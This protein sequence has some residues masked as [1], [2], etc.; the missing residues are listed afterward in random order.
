MGNCSKYLNRRMFF[1]F[2]ATFCI[3]YISIF[4][5][6]NHMPKSIQKFLQTI[7]ESSKLIKNDS[8][9]DKM[10]SYS[11]NTRK[12]LLRFRNRKV[13]RK[14]LLL[15]VG[16]FSAAQFIERR[17]G[18]RKT[19]MT[20]CTVERRISCKFFTDSLDAFGRPI[21]KDELHIL[22]EES[23]R[24]NQDL[25]IVESPRGWNLALR[26]LV[27]IENARKEADFEFFLRIDDDHF[28]CMDRLI[29]ELPYRP[30]NGLVWGWQHC[31]APG[32]FLVKFKHLLI[33]SLNE[34]K[35]DLTSI[36]SLYLKT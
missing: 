34:E 31:T 22:K 12:K 13:S 11:L 9:H 4:S 33:H 32:A 28:P 6:M 35:S 23:E 2:V 5:T 19:W 17:N 18:I 8:L 10:R 30:K 21:D 20:E 16:I 3:V 24:H 29:R 1:I 27:V 15:Y 26:F 14:N 7:K 36:H 25:A